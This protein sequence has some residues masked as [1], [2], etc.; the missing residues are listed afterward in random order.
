MRAGNVLVARRPDGWEV[1]GVID[2]ENAIAADPLIDLAKTDYYSLGRGE[3]ECSALF[4]GYGPLPADAVERL[5]LYRL[6]HAVELWGWF[7]SIGTV[8]PVGGIADDIVRPAR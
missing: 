1:S 5:E 7:R 6:Y 4:E 8:G 2:V 3:P